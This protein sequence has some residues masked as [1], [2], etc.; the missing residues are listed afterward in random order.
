MAERIKVVV[1]RKFA[2]EWTDISIVQGLENYKGFSCCIDGSGAI[3]LRR[4][5]NEFEFK[6]NVDRGYFQY[7][8]PSE[9]NNGKR[10]LFKQHR[11]V[12]FLWIPNPENKP[13][14][15]HI[16]PHDWKKGEIVDNSLDNLRWCTYA[17][18]NQ[19]SRIRTDNTSGER[20]I[21]EAIRHGKPRWKITVKTANK[22]IQRQRCRNPNSDVI[23][24]HIIEL[25]DE[26]LKEHGSFAV[27]KELRSKH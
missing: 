5:S 18:N 22:P 2:R 10:K 14:V 4:D 15:D 25:R 19:N 7:Q 6:A 1:K 9:H 21:F 20:N 24:Q 11:L 27:A 12:A 13:W 8:L 17:E 16:K 23:P 3:R 26:L